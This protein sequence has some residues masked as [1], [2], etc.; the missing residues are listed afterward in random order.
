MTE[1]EKGKGVPGR[2]SKPRQPAI[3]YLWLYHVQYGLRRRVTHMCA[4]PHGHAKKLEFYLY[5][6]TSESVSCLIVYSENNVWVLK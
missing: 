2:E 4:G 6:R 1:L 3:L 5:G